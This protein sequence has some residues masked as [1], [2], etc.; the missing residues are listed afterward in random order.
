[1]LAAA[2]AGV[3]AWR[4]RHAAASR[5]EAA[6]VSLAAAPAR[7]AVQGGPVAGRAH[8]PPSL[9]GTAPDGSLVVDESGRLAVTRE[10]RRFF[11][12][13]LAAEDRPGRARAR[14][15]AATRRRLPDG[16]VPEAIGLRDRY[17]ASR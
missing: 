5:P 17:L 9:S 7:D 11:D 6:V 8:L 3:L 16:A 14:L 15:A 4:G 2:L 13:Y 12:Y 10:T 1:M